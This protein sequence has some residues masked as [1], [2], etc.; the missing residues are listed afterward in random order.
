MMTNCAPMI[1]KLNPLLAFHLPL[2]RAYIGV[3]IHV[4]RLR[5]RQSPAPKQ[6]RQKLDQK[7]TPMVLRCRTLPANIYRHKKAFWSLTVLAEL[8]AELSIPHLSH[9]ATDKNVTADEVS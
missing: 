3:I 4:D 5:K 7:A 9:V 6:F 8:F 2:R 1:V